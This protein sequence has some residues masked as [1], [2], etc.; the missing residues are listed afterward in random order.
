MGRG[1]SHLCVWKAGL[2]GCGGR[3]F[4]SVPVYCEEF[5]STTHFSLNRTFKVKGEAWVLANCW[6][7]TII[8]CAKAVLGDHPI[9]LYHYVARNPVFGVH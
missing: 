1:V 8:F 5:A 9:L 7:M 6:V 3:P 4:P 2:W